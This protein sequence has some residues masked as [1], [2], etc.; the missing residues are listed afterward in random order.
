MK[1]LNQESLGVT[2]GRS[3]NV[4][5]GVATGLAN[6]AGVVGADGNGVLVGEPL[7]CGVAVEL[8]PNG[9]PLPLE[10][11]PAV[12]GEQLKLL[13]LVANRQTP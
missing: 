6:I 3:S 7:G 12:A 4:V 10:I 11:T 9:V 2:S 8:S 1:L 5:P 13:K